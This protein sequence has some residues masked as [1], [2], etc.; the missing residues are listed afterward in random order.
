MARKRSAPST[1]NSTTINRPL[2]LLRRLCFALFP[3]PFLRFVYRSILQ[4]V[5]SHPHVTHFAVDLRFDPLQVGEEAPLGNGGDMR[6]DA[7]LFLGFTTAP[8]NAA[9]HRAFSGQFTNFCHNE[10]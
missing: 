10:P 7:A 1:I 3:L 6:A 5:C 9:L 8:K 4:G 2:P